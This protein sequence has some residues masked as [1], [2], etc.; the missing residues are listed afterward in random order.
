LGWHFVAGR[1]RVPR[2]AAGMTA[3]RTFVTTPLLVRERS[4]S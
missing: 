3:L 2:P 4:L 1:K